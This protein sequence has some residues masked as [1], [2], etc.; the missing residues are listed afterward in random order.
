[1]LFIIG[2]AATLPFF[3]VAALKTENPS[4]TALMRQ[5]VE[6]AL[7]G[8]KRLTITQ[9]WISLA[10]LPKHVI[11]AVIV[12]EDGTFYTHSG[13][14]WF[15][16]QE[17]IEKDLQEGRAVRGAS[18]ITQQLAKNLYLSTSKDP[19]RKLREFA[20]TLM[21]ENELSKNRILELYLN[22]IEWGRG[23]FG[24]EAAAEAYF[25]KSASDL[26]LDEAARLAA[27]I[28]S[29]I[30]HAPNSDGRYVMRRKQIVLDRM[31]ARNFIGKPSEEGEEANLQ[32]VDSAL[33]LAIDSNIRSAV[34]HAAVDSVRRVPAPLDSTGPMD[35]TG[36]DEDRDNGL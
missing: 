8:G 14:D 35:S 27:V 29:P 34:P 10:K 2:E 36:T 32:V 19:V 18:T 6:E 15:E 12:E 5:R 28:P 16:V 4:E 3:S 31:L 7:S 13:F 25:G 23:I 21:L 30:R 20:I 33:H 17:S 1:M 9:R 26:S 11:D 22:V 24:I